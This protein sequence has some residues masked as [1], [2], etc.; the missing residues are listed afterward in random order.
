[1]PDP[2]KV[3]KYNQ[4]DKSGER[5]YESGVDRGMVYVYN[6]AASAEIPS[7]YS[8]KVQSNAK[9]AFWNGLTAFNESPEGA[10][11]N[12]IYADN[13]KY[14]TLRAAEDYKFTIEA[15]AYPAA[16]AACNGEKA[17][18]SAVNGN[19][20]V[21]P[22]LRFGQQSRQTFGFCC[23]T[24]LGNDEGPEKGY[25]LYIVYGATCDP[26]DKNHE[27]ENDNPDAATMS[28]SCSTVAQEIANAGT[29][30]ADAKATAKFEICVYKEWADA[31]NANHQLWVNVQTLEQ[32]L[33]GYDSGNTHVDGYLPTP[34][35]I[36]SILH[37]PAPTT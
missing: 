27:T 6:S 33:Y 11:A 4:W 30:G 14:L 2:A 28:W 10:D 3:T 23:R 18:L 34:D 20:R 7:E 24:N 37:T 25:R 26:S 12:D 21:V 9:G 17:A 8:G 5:E 32:M 22:I 36:Y 13:K 16:F 35:I 29:Y 15:L 19:G 1:M 31:N